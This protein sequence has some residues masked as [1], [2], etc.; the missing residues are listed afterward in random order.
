MQKNCFFSL[1]YDII[2]GLSVST[3][4]VSWH[5]VKFVCQINYKNEMTSYRATPAERNVREKEIHKIFHVNWVWY[6]VSSVWEARM[7]GQKSIQ[8]WKILTDNRTKDLLN[9]FDMREYY[10]TQAS[11]ESYKFYFISRCW[12]LNW[13]LISNTDFECCY[14]RARATT[15]RFSQLYCRG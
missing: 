2:W 13:V 11:G 15:V 6:A 9:A 8:S 12:T 14:L 1:N 4:N 7:G 3:R 5:R 10:W